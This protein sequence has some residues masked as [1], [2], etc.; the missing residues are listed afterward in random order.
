MQCR[1]YGGSP[2]RIAAVHGGPGAPGSAAG[3]AI[4]LAA[5]GTAVLEPLQSVATIAGQEAELCATLEAHAQ[6]PC[7]L[8]GWSWGAWLSLIVAAKHPE[9]VRKLILVGS[10]PFQE[11]YTRGML[12]A[13][14]ARLSAEERAE[15]EKI[16][17]HM[18]DP[19]TV[20][21]EGLFARFGELLSRGDTFSALPSDELPSAEELP[22]Q[23]EVYAG[24]W[25]QAAA[26]RANGELLALATEVRCPVAAIHG[27][28]DPHPAEGVREPLSRV[29][30]D[31]RF[32]LLQR[33]GHEPW[34]ERHARVRF[35]EVLSEILS[36]DSGTS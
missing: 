33:C 9:L 7:V 36:G 24:V 4:R 27:D 12:A 2:Y 30:P 19:G 31:F 1:H 34:I 8:V 17:L 11:H 23:P 28:C 32:V 26:M 13:R 14:L 5:A 16:E 25:P 35:F 21:R 3:L 20:S 29:L 15:V 6:L 22:V 10:G 18:A